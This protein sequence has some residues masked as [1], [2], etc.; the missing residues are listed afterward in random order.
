MQNDKAGT[1][2]LLAGMVFPKKMREK[3]E[4]RGKG[5]KGTAFRPYIQQTTNR[6]L[7]PE[8]IFSAE[9]VALSG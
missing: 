7:G 5:L 6:P 8:G 9:N 2:R 4:K 1:K 3:R